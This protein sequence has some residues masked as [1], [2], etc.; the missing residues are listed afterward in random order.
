[1]RDVNAAASL[2]TTRAL[3]VFALLLSAC[4]RGPLPDFDTLWNFDDPAASEERFREVLDRDPPDL[5]YR[6]QLT[7][8]LARAIGLQGRFDEAVALLDSV[9]HELERA[10]VVT[11]VRWSLERGRVFSSSGSPVLARKPFEDAIAIADGASGG[12][13]ASLDRYVVDAMHM[14]AIISAGKDRI[15]WNQKAIARAEASK[16]PATK[17]WLGSLFNNLGFAQLDLGRYRNALSTHRRAEAWYAAKGDVRWERTSRWAV[18]KTLRL[19][20]RCKEALPIQQE[21]E[22]AWD[23][24]GAP[25]GFVYEEIAEC[26][27][28]LGEVDAAR[29]Y[30]ARAYEVLKEDSWIVEHE[31]DRLE[32]IEVLSKPSDQAPP[33]TS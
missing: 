19:L 12:A 33:E 28:V 8:Q 14:L 1:M 7:T 13:D 18:G 21:L 10:N 23:A 11:R 22:A 31:P 30:F 25:D 16:D 4:E 3:I 2:P 20:D 29:G 24:E 32:R 9:E 6:V 27:L 5:D 17:D 15:A 26:R